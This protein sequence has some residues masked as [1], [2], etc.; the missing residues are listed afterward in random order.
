MRR[1]Q[2]FPRRCDRNRETCYRAGHM[3]RTRGQSL[4]D[5]PIFERYTGDLDVERLVTAWVD[6]WHAR[7]QELRQPRRQMKGAD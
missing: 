3:A 7:D 4:T 1:R 6:G 2:R 5:C